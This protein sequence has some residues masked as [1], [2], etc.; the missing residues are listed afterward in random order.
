MND[1]IDTTTPQGKLTFNIFAS[2]AEFERD[3]ISERTKAGLKAARARG[4]LGGRPKGL[5]KESQSKACAAETLYNERKLTV[6]QICEQLSVSKATL[7]SYLRYRGVQIGNSQNENKSE[8]ISQDDTEH[9]MKSIKVLLWLRVENNQGWMRRKKG[10][11]KEIE[12]YVLRRYDMRKLK[13]DGWEYEL[14]IS[15]TDDDDLDETIYEILN[16]AESTADMRTCFT[17]A[18]VRTLDGE[19]SW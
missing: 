5:S 4:R 7:Y 14:T 10:A 1:P 13:K 2:L 12:D 8:K 16:E 15:Y 18:D 6:K 9:L 3:I 17:E 19:H 11:R